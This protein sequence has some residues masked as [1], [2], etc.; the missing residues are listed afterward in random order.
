MPASERLAPEQGRGWERAGQ[1]QGPGQ[2]SLGSVGEGRRGTQGCSQ[3]WGLR[4]QLDVPAMPWGSG[5]V[6][7][8]GA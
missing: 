8:R 1:A 6:D 3:V 5:E 4:T 7:E 2:T